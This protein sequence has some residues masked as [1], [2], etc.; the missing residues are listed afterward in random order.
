MISVRE[1]PRL[2]AW[3]DPAMFAVRSTLPAAIQAIM[4]NGFLA[5]T[6]EDALIPDFLFPTIA[7]PRPW[8]ANLGDTQTFTRTGLLTPQTTPVTGSDASVATY[9]VEQFSMTMDQ[10][11]QGVDTNMLQSAMTLASLF[12]RNIRTLGINAGQSLNRIA[13][14]KLYAAYAGG[15]SYIT[16]AATSVNQVV[17]DATGFGTVLVNGVPTPVSGAN[18]L[19]VTVNGVANTV[20]GVNL[21]TNTLTLGTSIT[22]VIGQAVISA[23]A[24]VSYRPNARTTS[25]DVVAGDVANMA[26]FRSGVA[27]LRN[28]NVPDIDG[29]YVAHIDSITEQELFT[30]ADFK[31][32]YQG[33]GDSPVFQQM[34]I[35]RFL[36]IDWV[37]NQEVPTVTNIAGVVVHRPI[38]LG[39]ESLIAGPFERMGTLLAELNDNLDSD[40]QMLGPD[41]A[42]VALIV[43]PPLDRFQQVVSAAWSF[44]GDFAVP[45]D[46]LT[47]DAA[48]YKRAVV[49]EHA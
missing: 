47:G 3:F 41:N 6:F 4:Q 30:D 29:Y 36:G 5:R 33:R 11:G 49:V 32:A 8:V 24:P 19:N 20:T 10:Y 45:S 27:R 22:T 48:L 46:S 31:Q 18:P 37:R 21:G 44:V 12:A 26:S 39:D 7:T 42:Q 17:A 15:R 28:Q 14:N 9:S 23:L 43:R 25:N 16:A 35:G 2:P 1:R 34:S 38:I 40:I 13:R